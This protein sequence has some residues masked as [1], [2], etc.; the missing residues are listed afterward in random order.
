MKSTYKAGLRNS[1]AS[2]AQTPRTRRCPRLM[3]ASP[4]PLIVP[5]IICE[6]QDNLTFDFLGYALAD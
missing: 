4:F 2:G 6:I 1:M 5:I 3:N